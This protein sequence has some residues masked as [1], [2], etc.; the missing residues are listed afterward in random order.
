MN[1]SPASSVTWQ[2][3]RR[4]EEG[5][6]EGYTFQQYSTTSSTNTLGM[7]GVYCIETTVIYSI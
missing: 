6:V 7:E 4:R 3:C 2:V 1:H 5:T